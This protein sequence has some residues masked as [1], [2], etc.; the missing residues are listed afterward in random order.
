MP[1]DRATELELQL[2]KILW[3]Q[4]P[5]SVREVRSQLAEQGKEIAHTTVITVLNI[6]VEKKFLKRKKQKNAFL[7]TPR[8]SR[9]KMVGSIVG[10]VVERVFDGSAHG[11]MLS[12]MESAEIDAQELRKIRQLIDSKSK[13]DD[14]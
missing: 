3:K 13:G 9:S 4:S 7:F 12:L 6:M 11:L 10:D 14:A 2:L 8:V 5:L 1:T